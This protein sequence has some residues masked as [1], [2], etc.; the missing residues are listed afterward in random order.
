MLSGIVRSRCWASTVCAS[1]WLSDDLHR[2]GESRLRRAQCQLGL[3]R[4]ELEPSLVATCPAGTGDEDGADA[5]KQHAEAEYQPDGNEGRASLFAPPH[6]IEPRL[7][8]GVGGDELV[9]LDLTPLFGNG[10]SRLGAADHGRD[11]AAC[12]LLP[13]LEGL[14][15]AGQGCELLRVVLRVRA[16]LLELGLQHS[17]SL[18]IRIQENGA[19]SRQERVERALCPSIAVNMLEAVC[20]SPKFVAAVCCAVRDAKSTAAAT[21]ATA[22]ANSSHPKVRRIPSVI[23]NSGSPREPNGTKRAL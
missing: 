10:Q 16:G 7:V 17:P 4:L 6:R 18:E 13:A 20:A 19:T 2:F 21:T 8:G 1:P 22:A 14:T 23:D 3:A 11:L 12:E 9:E 5:G 15:L